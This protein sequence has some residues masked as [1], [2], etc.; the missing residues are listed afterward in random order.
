MACETVACETM[1]REAM[2]RKT[3]DYLKQAIEEML[4]KKESLRYIDGLL[5]FEYNDVN[6]LMDVIK[7]ELAVTN[8]SHSDKRLML[9]PKNGD[10]M[11]YIIHRFEHK[12]DKIIISYL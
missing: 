8:F 12:I 7:T 10:M 6:A 1:T 2:T 5:P 11:T 4:E 3:I 9:K